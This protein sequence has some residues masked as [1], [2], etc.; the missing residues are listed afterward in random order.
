[1]DV[2]SLCLGVLAR[3]EASGY[4]IKKS[5]EEGPFAH[6][7]EASFG[8]IYP[9]LNRLTEEGLVSCT[10][11]SQDKRPD[12][13]VYSI[14]ARG[15]EAFIE[16]LSGPPAPDQMRSDFLFIIFFGHL[17]PP[18]RLAQLIDRRIAWHEACLA[19]MEDCGAEERPAGERFVHGLG[20]AV[21]GA[22]ARYLKENRDDLLAE[23]AGA[24]KLVAE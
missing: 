9:A 8:S 18:A 7:H 24:A 19:R 13:K 14:T 5:F 15:R 1:M 16:R 12:K 6:I 3:G 20:L 23:L 4:E 17:L 11:M 2:K 21:Y 22:A 10:E